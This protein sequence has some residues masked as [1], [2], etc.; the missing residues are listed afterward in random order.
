MAPFNFPALTASPPSRRNWYQELLDHPDCH[1][2]QQVS[3]AYESH[4]TAY[5]ATNLAAFTSDTNPVKPNQAL[6]AHLLRRNNAQEPG[7]PSIA[8]LQ[9]MDVNCLGISTRPS[10][11]ITSLICNIQAQFSELIGKDFYAMPRSH[12]HIA[13]LELAHRHSLTYLH[14]V[15]SSV[16]TPR[17]QKILNLPSKPRLVSPCLSVDAAGLALSFIPDRAQDHTYHHLRADMQAE[18]LESGVAFDMCYTAPSAHVTLGRFVGSEFFEVKERREEFL[19]LVRRVNEELEK[20]GPEWVVEEEL[21]LQAGYL[22]FGVE[23]GEAELVGGS[24]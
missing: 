11:H 20:E 24:E 10:Q 3:E 21:E 7:E 15:S 2:S 14:S 12:L 23:K 9:A 18:A 17:L 16:G 13:I 1:D 19:E 5:M 22:K 6:I 8:D 4:R